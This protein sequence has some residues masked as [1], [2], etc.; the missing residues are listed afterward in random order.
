MRFQNQG[1]IVYLVWSTL[2]VAG[3]ASLIFQR[4]ELAFVAIAT[5]AASMVPAALA[6]RM[7]IRL[8]VPFLSFTVIF[9]FATLFLGEALDFYNRY[10]WWDLLLH[11]SSAIGFGLVGFVFIFYLFE[12]D[13]YAAPPWAT[14]FLGWCFAVAIGTMW[15][16]FEFAMDQIFG[17]NMQKSGLMDTMT[18]LIVDVV[19]AAL[20]ALSGFLYLKGLERGGLLAFVIADFVEMNRRLFKRR[21]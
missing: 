18:D 20:G 17:T 7:D 11:G 21:R 10:W 2:V 19:C 1:V 8:P 16:I 4:W 14:A 3:L 6:A 5:L 13:K 9:I 12:G 15:E